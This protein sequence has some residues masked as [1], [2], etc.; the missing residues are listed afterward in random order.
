MNLKHIVPTSTFRRA[1]LD[2]RAECGGRIAPRWWAEV[3]AGYHFALHSRLSLADAA[4]PYAQAVLRP[5]QDYY[6]A[7]HGHAEAAL[8]YRFPL[9]L[10][11]RRLPCFV[12]AEG[13]C[14]RTDRHTEACAAA[15]TFGIF[16]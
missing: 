12:R 1:A 14:L 15:L 11:G 5:D 8:T 2:L 7:H 4:A 10:H 3:R 16:H 6:G 13:R 9:A